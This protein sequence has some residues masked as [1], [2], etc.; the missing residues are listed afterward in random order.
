MYNVM[1]ELH[2]SQAG[3]HGAAA[4]QL[5]DKLFTPRIKLTDLSFFFSAPVLF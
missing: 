2:F 1:I 5:A 4:L 3:L